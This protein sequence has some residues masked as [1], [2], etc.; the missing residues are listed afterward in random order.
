MLRPNLA[1][2][3]FLLLGA[4]AARAETQC[5]PHCDYVHYYGPSDYT[6]RQPGLF[7][8]P[9]CTPDGNCSPQL[10]YRYSGVDVG[11]RIVIQPRRRVRPAEQLR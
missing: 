5:Y 9:R 1:V 11:Q 7:G 3:A 4:G 2:L 10:A 8:F 6:Y